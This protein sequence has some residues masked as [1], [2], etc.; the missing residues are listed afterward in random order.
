MLPVHRSPP[1]LLLPSAYQETLKKDPYSYF[2]NVQG[3]PFADPNG[4]PSSANDA[5]G[6][7]FYLPLL[8]FTPANVAYA[9]S[10]GNAQAL[11][12]LGTQPVFPNNFYPAMKNMVDPS[13]NYTYLDPPTACNAPIWD[14]FS[15]G[16][17]L[18][19]FLQF[20]ALCYCN[21][22]LQGV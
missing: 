17:G 6:G 12:D 21:G 3:P 7:P 18:P 11:C 5:A 13:Q 22:A 19:T 4:C 16:S 20:S 14:F 1:G 9:K 15:L 10:L 2:Y 8:P